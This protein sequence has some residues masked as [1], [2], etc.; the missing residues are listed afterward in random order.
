MNNAVIETAL[1]ADEVPAA[2]GAESALAFTGA[3]K[4]LV[5]GMLI[6]G[7]FWW[8]WILFSDRPALGVS[9][10]T[11]LLCGVTLLYLG[12]SGVRQSRASLPC[13][14]IL[15]LSCVQFTLFDTT[16]LQ[17]FNLIFMSLVYLY[18]LSA[19]C[20]TRISNRLSGTVAFDMLNQCVLVPFGNIAALFLAARRGVSEMKRGKELLA[21]A[22]GLLV[23]LPLFGVVLSLL[24][25]ADDAFGALWRAIR[26]VF[27]L[28]D[29]VQ[30][31]IEFIFGIPVAAYLYGAVFGNASRRGA[32]VLNEDGIASG[33]LRIRLVPNMAF[34]A[35]LVALGAIYALFFVALGKYFFSAFAGRLPA[36]MSYAEYARKGFFELCGVATINLAIIACVYLLIRRSGDER[37]RALRILTGLLS[38][39]TVLLVVTAM[40]KMFLYISAYGLTRLRVYTSWFM[41][42]L[43]IAFVLLLLWHFRAFD[44]A[45]PLLIVCVVGFMALTWADTDGLIAKYNIERYE[46]GRTVAL[47]VQMLRTLSDAAAPY[48]YAAWEREKEKDP[49]TETALELGRA[50]LANANSYERRDFSEQNVQAFRAA[51]LSEKA[52]R[53]SAEAL[54]PEGKTVYQ[55]GAEG[56]RPIIDGDRFYLLK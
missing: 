56:V 3:D 34:C 44:P 17:F 15:C 27:D 22:V 35:P 9:L 31:A 16:P 43:L 18:H 51:A 40:S 50:L 5:L 25:E 26:A 6:C 1:R 38:A 37:P 54:S 2:S 19:S 7:F 20:G 28:P 30:Y 13:L 12:K 46:S 39:F 24:T 10:F 45:K 48:L 49:K 21:A 53:D 55:G 23:F 8:E 11:L 42:L 36:A 33:L 41:L 52:Q 14:V 29:F 4:A 32:R 47:D